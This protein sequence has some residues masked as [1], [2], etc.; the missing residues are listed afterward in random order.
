MPIIVFYLYY[1]HYIESN[2]IISVKLNYIHY[3]NYINNFLIIMSTSDI[4]FKSLIYGSCSRRWTSMVLDGFLKRKSKSLLAHKNLQRR[5]SIIS[6][7]V[8]R[9]GSA[10]PLHFPACVCKSSPPSAPPA[11]AY[12]SFPLSPSLSLFTPPF[13]NK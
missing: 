8:R 3:G 11:R 1:G 12:I 2:L 10:D 13:S 9:A 5:R 7:Q 4:A 6:H